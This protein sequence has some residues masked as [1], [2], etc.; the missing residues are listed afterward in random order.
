MFLAM[1]CAKNGDGPVYIPQEAEQIQTTKELLESGYFKANRIFLIFEKE[2]LPA[3]DDAEI[4]SVAEPEQ[5][6]AARKARKRE[7]DKN[8]AAKELPTPKVKGKRGRPPKVKEDVDSRF[9]EVK[10]EKSVVRKR[11]FT[12][13][14]A[15]SIAAIDIAAQHS[16]NEEALPDLDELMGDTKSY[17]LRRRNGNNI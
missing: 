15:E 14:S 7:T 4:L 3:D 17:H 13:V 11:S 16:E 1:D 5:S 10:E 9:L 12:E 6:H 2:E 8:E